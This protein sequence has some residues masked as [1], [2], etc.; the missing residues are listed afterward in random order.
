[1]EHFAPLLKTNYY[2]MK[3]ILL[4]AF[5]ASVMLGACKKS[6][7]AEPEVKQGCPVSSF[8][9]S[10]DITGRLHIEDR[11][12]VNYD[13]Q[14]RVAAI[15]EDD[16]ET[17]F[18]YQANQIIEI[19]D[20]D[21]ATYTLDANGKVTGVI[22]SEGDIITTKYNSEGYLSELKHVVSYSTTTISLVYT[23]GEV[24]KI[25]EVQ[26]TDFGTNTKTTDITYKEEFSINDLAFAQSFPYMADV[27]MGAD[28]RMYLKSLGKNQ[29]RLINSL[30]VVRTGSNGNNTNN[31]NYNYQK[32]ANGNVTKVNMV[33]T[34]NENYTGSYD[35]TYNCN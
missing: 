14:G 19:Q 7:D 28:T 35:F 4:L 13:A 1:M 17:N 2:Y 11:R 15:V 25:V 3:K 34:G 31:V 33:S 16:Y 12:A 18:T 9:Y 20:G 6:N 29:K 10:E 22:T 23:N 32:D 27:Y 26:V 8:Q 21:V 30:K 5:T 24:T